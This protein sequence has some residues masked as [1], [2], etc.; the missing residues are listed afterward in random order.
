MDVGGFGLN[1]GVLLVNI[2]SA[3]PALEPLGHG[4]ESSAYAE[5]PGK[6]V[7]YA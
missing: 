7:F 4:I 3:R 2:V 5:L 6:R 1:E